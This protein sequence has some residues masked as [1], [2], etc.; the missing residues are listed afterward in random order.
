MIVL[1]TPTGHIGRELLSLLRAAGAPVRVIARDPARVPAGVDV[2]A[3]SHDDPAVLDAALGDGA[4]AL[5]LLV[6]PDPTTDDADAHYLR[7]ARPAAAAVARHGVGRVVMVSSFGRG[8]EADAGLLT[9]A[10]L[11][12]AEVNRAGA[13]TR[14]LRPPYFMENLLHLTGALAHGILPLPSD[15][16]RPLPTVAAA[17]VAAAAAALLTDTGWTGQEGVAVV[18]PDDL[19]PQGIAATL[20]EA[21]DR[22][23]AL[24]PITVA[25]YRATFLEHGASP[26][27]AD[28]TAAIVTAQ[29]RGVY[30]DDTLPDRRGATSLRAWARAVLAPALR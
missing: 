9:S 8:I 30:A 1:T 16:D 25:D 22:P 20:A 13:A 15:P 10:T 18:G 11:L 6:P 19:T 28:A 3:G 4:D 14:A 17:D 29:N 12:E 23:V 21:L 26:A 27:F 2:V 24:Q 7:F 5:F